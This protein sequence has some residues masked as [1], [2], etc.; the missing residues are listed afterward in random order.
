MELPLMDE[1]G[2][3]LGGRVKGQSDLFRVWACGLS[4]K[5][6]PSCADIPRKISLVDISK[7][8]NEFQ[9]DVTDSG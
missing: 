4:V 3:L 8:F 2:A 1:D 5:M 7:G 6:R 9:R